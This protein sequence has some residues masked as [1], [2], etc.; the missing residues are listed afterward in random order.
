MVVD[1]AAQRL[2]AGSRKVITTQLLIAIIVA[3]GFFFIEGY[4]GSV[5]AVAGG[6]IS[7]VT[8][9]ILWGGMNWSS[10]VSRHNPN[11]S[12]VILYV[13]AAFRFVMVLVMFVICLKVF[14]LAPLAVV[15]GFSLAQLAYL[16]NARG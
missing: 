3:G 2:A 13:S 10:S 12:Q 8:T 4:H 15:V 7:I 5:S 16:V 9:L 14:E 11:V 6:I 1:V